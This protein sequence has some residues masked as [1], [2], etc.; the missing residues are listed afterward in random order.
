MAKPVTPPTAPVPTRRQLDELE[1]LLQRMLELPVQQE[2]NSAL[3]KTNT[4]DVGATTSDRFPSFTREW[5]TPESSLAYENDWKQLPPRSRVGDLSDVNSYPTCPHL[6][7]ELH[8]TTSDWDKEAPQPT[9]DTNHEMAA[10]D[11]ESASA[12]P[13]E[14]LDR[15]AE[16][17]LRPEPGVFRILLGW[18]GLVCLVISLAILV[19]DWYGWTW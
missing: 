10:P 11:E 17:A 15:S 1:A 5:D 4:P 14:W 13:E 8:S 9:A 6:S 12:P 7:D 19:L 18:A 3:L 2:Q 16:E